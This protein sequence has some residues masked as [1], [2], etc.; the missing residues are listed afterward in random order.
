MAMAG[1]EH[2]VG[3]RYQRFLAETAGVGAGTL[4]DLI[5]ITMISGDLSC[6]TSWLDQRHGRGAFRRMFR[7][8]NYTGPDYDE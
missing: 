3:S 8:P 1:Y 4:H 2:G 7:S 6:L 5:V